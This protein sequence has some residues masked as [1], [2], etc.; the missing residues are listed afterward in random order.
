VDYD[1][2]RRALEVLC[3]AVPPEVGA[4][5]TNKSMAK[6][7]WE[8]IATRRVGGER[9]QRATLQRLRD[10]WEG[11]TFW[12]GEQVDALRLTNLKEQMAINGDT[13]L[14]KRRAVEKL[15]R[16]VP[17]KFEQLVIS[18]ETLLDLDELTIEGVTGRLKVVQDRDHAPET[19]AASGK[20]L[21]T[22]EQWRAFEKEEGAGSSRDGDRRRC[23]RGG[24]KNKAKGGDQDGGA[25]R[26][27]EKGGAA[28]DR[29]QNRDDLCLNCNHAGHW[30]RDC[31]QPRHDRGGAAHMEEVDEDHALF[32]A[33]GFPELD[34]DG[35]EGQASTFFAKS[36]NLAID[37]PKA[38]AFLHSET[39]GDEK[40]DGWYLD[41]G[42]THHMTSRRELFTDLDTSSRGMVRFGD[43]SKV[44]IHGVG[45]IIFEAKIGEHRVLHGVYYIPALRNSIMSL[46]RLDEG[47][48]KV[49]IEHGVLRIWDHRWRLLI[50]VRRGANHLY[51]L[52]INTAKPLCLAARKDDEAWRWHERYSHLHFDALHRLSKHG[53]ARGLL[54]ID[55]VA[56][57]CDTCVI[58]KH[59]RA[60]FSSEAQYRAQDPLELVHGDSRWQALLP[61]AGQ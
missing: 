4:P 15:L 22:A 44:E 42:A 9:V 16:C 48:S 55:H 30:A 11:L 51:V 43:E 26:G 10:E 3:A 7:A 57:F 59:R 8:A 2:D 5:I 27:G 17:K 18:I 13:D 35:G 53:M 49:L 25:D 36:T 29:R 33:C 47:G 1:E 50:K 14:D 21:Y 31:P 39:G 34:A 19:E 28:G 23:P 38:N 37:E 40:L 46:G 58:T 56:Q 20:L 32:F 41:T 60:P 12:L 6:H 45:S 54:E 61:V 52:D 24:K